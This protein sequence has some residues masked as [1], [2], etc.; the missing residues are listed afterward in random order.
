M[1]DRGLEALSAA[2]KALPT[3]PQRARQVFELATDDDPKMADAWLGRVAAG[4]RSLSTLRTLSQ[5]SRR[6][7]A[8]L[9]AL[10]TTPQALGAFFDIEYVRLEI[11]DETSAGLAYAA[12]LVDAGQ[13]GQASDELDALPPLPQV[14]YVRAVLASRTERWPD[15]LTAL[16]GCDTWQFV[17]LRRAASLL[18]AKAAANLG[19]FDRALAAV[20]RAGDTPSPSDPLLRDATFLRA[21]VARSQGEEEAARTLL[22][23]IRVRW[24]DF[25]LAKVAI[26]DVTYGLKVT[27]EATIDSRTDRWDPATETSADQR[28]AAEHADSARALL[29]TAE[30]DLAAMVGLDDVK[31]R[32]T[33]IKAGTIARVL[34]QRKGLPTPPVSRHLLMV[35]PPGVGKTASARAIANIF[36][37]LGLLPRSEIFETKPDSLLGPHVGETDSNTRTFLEKAIGATVFFDEFGDTIKP[38]YTTGDPYGQAIVAALVPWMENHRDEAVI[39]AAGYPRACQRVLDSNDGLQSRFSTVI[40]FRSYEPDALMAIARGIVAQGGDSVEDGAIEH[41]LAGPFARY[42]NEQFESPDGDVV[43]LIDILGNGRFVRTVVERSQEVRDLRVITELGLG[44]ADLT[45]ETLGQDI[46]E[47]TLSLLTR[48]DLAEGLN[49]A[50][51]PAQR[52]L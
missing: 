46:G 42:Y 9:R 35:G 16:I 4:D 6:V 49:N 27:D 1:S 10:G 15:V 17:F 45:D 14:A 47:E 31:K 22:T 26:A 12:A 21:L 5:V 41:V 50:L 33:T 28:A 20:G 43:R 29:A 36:C 51:P 18:E 48:E 8:D 37:G 34:R 44:A 25:E 2:V 13:F 52:G 24:P 19:L 32:I 38:G 39:I 11:I 7:G 23:D 30:K 3:A 40:E